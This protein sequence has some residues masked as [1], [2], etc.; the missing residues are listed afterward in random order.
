MP[1]HKRMGEAIARLA[2]I[3]GHVQGVMR[4]A[5]EGRACEDLLIQLA[6][7]KAAVGQTARI[8]LEDHMEC[9]V[10]EGLENGDTAKTVDDLKRAL[11]KFL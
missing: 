3:Q 6:A 2:K 7:V 11:A 5:E 1:V 8:I 9:C 10:L 4:M